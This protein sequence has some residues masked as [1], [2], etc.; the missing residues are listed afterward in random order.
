VTD[1]DLRS[2]VAAALLSIA[3]MGFNPHQ[4]RDSR[5]RWIKLADH[6]KAPRRRDRRQMLGRL[7]KGEP[8][9]LE[10]RD[11]A[12][13]EAAFGFQDP[14]TGLRAVVRQARVEPDAFYRARRQMEVDLDFRSADG[15][16][17]GNAKRTF[18]EVEGDIEVRHDKMSVDAAYRRGGFSRR[19]LAEMEDRYRQMGVDQVTLQTT[20]VGGYA[21]AKSGFDFLDDSNARSLADQVTE[22]AEASPPPPGVRAQLD[23]LVR[24]AGAG[25]G[26]RPLPMEFAMLGWEPGATAWFG[27]GSMLGTG[28]E[29]IKKL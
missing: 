11:L 24:R 29:G 26:G 2:R 21:W 8:R 4:R 10:G 15:Q 14:Q 19:W 22:Y 25:G 20:N 13:V 9:R 12:E 7:M 23:E 6:E 1:L 5:G 27:K 3:A 28:W 18:S 16:L 17:V